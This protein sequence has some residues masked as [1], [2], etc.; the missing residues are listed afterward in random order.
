MSIVLDKKSKEDEIFDST[1]RP[2]KWE[3]YIGQEKVK[4]N[5]R[6]IISAAKKRKQPPDHLLLYGNSGLGKTTLAHLIAKEMGSPVRATSG[7]GL[8]NA[9]DLVAILT[10]LSDGEVLFIDECHRLNKTVEE[11]L[12]PAMEDY[13]LNII[14]GRGPMARTME[15]KIPHFTLIGATTRPALLSPPLRNRFG[16][17]FQLNFY[18][19]K[20]IEKIIERSSVL[21]NLKI[22]KEAIKVIAQRSRF[23]PRV[24]NRLL[25]RVRDFAEVEGDGFID[26]ETA[27]RSLDFL[28]VDEKGL[29]IGDRRLLKAAIEKFNGGPVGLQ[30][31][32]AA[33]MEEEDSIL[34][35]YEPYL[36]QLGFIERTPRGRMITEIAYQHLGIKNPKKQ[37]NLL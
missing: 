6:I 21:L 23:T 12:Y 28:E 22:D 33:A 9:G 24:A 1:L 15:L 17:T 5:I 10:N 2:Q 30:A 20:D 4:E 36:M 8:E 37:N 25:K 3:E 35:M 18:E 7:P 32:S 13:K 11:Y 16:A 19:Q 31:L 29:E 27:E 26:K 34:D 14:L